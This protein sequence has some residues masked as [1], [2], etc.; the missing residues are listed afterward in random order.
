MKKPVSLMI[1]GVY[2]SDKLTRLARFD[3]VLVK[4]LII[5]YWNRNLNP[6]KR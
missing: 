4:K 6:T 2:G 1:A 5:L 3:P